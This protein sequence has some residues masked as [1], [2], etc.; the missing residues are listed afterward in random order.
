MFW[1]FENYG[2]VPDLVTTGKALQISAVLGKEKYFP[3]E[4]GRIS[5]TWAEGNIY[6]SALGYMVTKIV[7]EDGLLK[8]AQEMGEYFCE[9]LKNIRTGYK[10]P[11]PINPPSGYNPYCQMFSHVRGM[12]LMIGVTPLIVDDRDLIVKEAAKRGLLI[13]GCGKDS[14]RFLPPL[15]VNKHEIDVCIDILTE[16]GQIFS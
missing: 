5:G 9:R 13:I 10:K 7:M 8:N 11:A 2:I 1:C 16:I 14:I 3:T 6:N 4:K 12:G 15:N